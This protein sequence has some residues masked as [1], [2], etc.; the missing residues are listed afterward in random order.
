MGKLKAAFTSTSVVQAI[1]KESLHSNES[2]E[3]TKQTIAKSSS[4]P[5]AQVIKRESFSGECTSL[6]RNRFKKI[7]IIPSQNYFISV[8]S[9]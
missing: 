9:N 4:I 3:G 1:R 5:A 6:K 8:D 7:H 2:I